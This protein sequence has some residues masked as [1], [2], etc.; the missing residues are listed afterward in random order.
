[1]TLRVLLPLFFLSAALAFPQAAAIDGQIEGIVRDPAGAPI[2]KA[3][4]K[5]RNLGTG[6]ERASE[7]NEVGYYRF[8]VLPRGE[9]E[10][11][12]SSSGFNTIKQTGIVINAGTTATI[13]IDLSVQSTSTEI[14]V[15]ASGP[16]TEPG[17]TDIGST[18]STNQVQNLPLVSRNPYNFVFFQPN[19]TGR[20]NTEFGVPRKINSNG[21]SGRINYQLDGSNNV[22][23]DRAG[24]RLIPI[25]NTFVEEVAFVSNGFAPEFGNT[26]GMVANT[27]TKSGNNDYHGEGAYIFRRTDFSAAPALLREGATIPQTNVDSFYGNGG[28]RIIRDKLF[29]YGAW[30]KVKRDLPQVVTVTPAI[31]TQ[32]GL[33]TSF[34]DPIPFNQNVQFFFGKLDYQINNNHRLSLRLNGHRNNSP[35]NGGGGLTVVSRTYNFVDRSYVGAAQLVS[36]LSPNIVNE[37]RFQTPWRSQQQQAFEATGTGPSINITGVV[38]FG[39]SEAV[40]FNF[41]EATPEYGDNLSINSG[42][43]SYKFGFTMR[44]IRDTQVA[45]TFGRYTFANIQSYLD[46][47]NGTNPRS[48]QNFTQTIGEPELKYNSLFSSF[49][50]QDTF[51]PRPNIT[52]TY[53]LRYDVYKMPSANST[54]PF[55]FS[56]RFR[57]DRNNF[58]PRLGFSWALGKTQRTVIRASAGMFY[59]PPQTDVYRRALLNNGQGRFL[60]VT[61]PI[62]TPNFPSILTSL[63]TGTNLPIQSIDTISPDFATLYSGNLN[64]SITREIAPK[65]AITA[66]YLW[67]RGNRLPVYRNINLLPS[68]Q[69]LADGRPIWISTAGQRVDPR[70]NN[71]LAAESA[72]QSSY[73]GGTLTL[74]RRYGRGFEA[75]ASYTWSHAIDDA[76]EQNNIDSGAFLLSDLSNRRRDKGN[77]L[78]DRRHSLQ[79]A[80]VYEPDFKF[81][82]KVASYLIKNNRLG[83]TVTAISGDVFNIGSNRVLNNDQ[84]TGAAFQRPLFI[85]RNTYRGPATYQFDV[86][87]SR[88]FPIRERMRAEFFAESTNLLNHTNVTGVN[89]AASVDVNGFITAPP[90]YAWTSA[91][92]QRLI[93]LGLKFNF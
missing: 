30:E 89:T 34:A 18:L 66:T 57:T 81:D 55:S 78:T 36:T 85:G 63:P 62:I 86:R 68:G 67:T 56:Q 54:S 60:Q 9:Y 48:Y 32:V 51:K 50:A 24:I 65:T 83:F 77:S 33:P 31:L 35:F 23:S 42:R 28:G 38:Q 41:T 87:Y 12:V 75:F 84:A 3:S 80:G 53:G 88:I 21:F 43:H 7:T 11:V 16:V 74:N 45:A 70:F 22:Q 5:A 58:A 92:D 26:V 13:N 61:S 69:T 40:G 73:S 1:M 19:V 29:F 4:V 72:G 91:I 93:Q 27:I 37:F 15:S 76:P 64:F 82:S 20:P 90:S 46:A 44:H 2:A 52:L 59:D 49:Y 71:I 79:V 8:S 6:L 39:R 14:V 47:V 17:R 10:V 25:S